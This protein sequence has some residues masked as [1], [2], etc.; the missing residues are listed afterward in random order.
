MNITEGRIFQIPLFGGLSDFLTRVIPGMSVLLRQTD[1]QASFV[2]ADGKI[3]S[4]EIL[5]EGDI[6]SLVGQG[7][8]Y[9]DGTLDFTVQVKLL[10]KHTL[11]ADVFR[12][13]THPVSKMLEFHLGGTLDSPRW[14]PVHIPKEVFLMFD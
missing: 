13:V 8:Y 12:F 11:A 6:F 4:D 2:I 3:H 1:V 9:L 5:I 7:D 10:R 14:R